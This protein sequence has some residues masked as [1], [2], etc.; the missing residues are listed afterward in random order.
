MRN[1]Y[2]R[3][4]LNIEDP[5]SAFYAYLQ[6]A[7]KNNSYI[8]YFT[9][10]T[11]KLI[12]DILDEILG[13]LSIDVLENIVNLPNVN[14][15]V[16]YLQI[17]NSSQCLFT[18]KREIRRF[19]ELNYIQKILLES[20]ASLLKE[21]INEHIQ[22]KEDT[23]NPLQR[24]LFKYYSSRILK[25]L[26]NHL[27]Q[28][29]RIKPDDVLRIKE[30]IKEP[31]IIAE[32][33]IE[34]NQEMLKAAEQGDVNKVNLLLNNG[35][36]VNY[37][38]DD[39]NTAVTIALTKGYTRVLKAFV[40]HKPD[41]FESAKINKVIILKDAIK[42]Y[43]FETVK[44][45]VEEGIL[46]DLTDDEKNE[47][48]IEA[49]LTGSIRVVELL[50]SKGINPNNRHSELK[51]IPLFRVL[52]RDVA[53][54]KL[55]IKYKADLN[56]QGEDGETLL[57]KATRAKRTK[58]VKLL[59]AYGAD[60]T[61]ESRDG[62]TALISAVLNY[63]FIAVKLLL[64]H[65]AN[66]HAL[67]IAGSTAFIEAIKHKQHIITKLIIDE[68]KEFQYNKW[69]GTLIL[70][71]A[72]EAKS[73]LI[74]NLVLKLGINP[75]VQASYYE[76]VIEKI[77]RNK[78]SP[79]NPK[80]ATEQKITW[81]VKLLL[82]Y[83]ADPNYRGDKRVTRE[84]PLVIAI[85]NS[86]K[87]CV[88]WL[89][90]Y[91]AVIRNEG[92]GG[93]ALKALKASKNKEILKAI[94]KWVKFERQVIDFGE[95]ISDIKT[96]LSSKI[97]KIK[98]TLRLSKYEPKG[99]L[100][101]TLNIGKEKSRLKTSNKPEL[102]LTDKLCLAIKNK[103]IEEFKQLLNLNISLITTEDISWLLYNTVVNDQLEMAKIILAHKID[104][105]CY[106]DYIDYH[107]LYYAVQKNKIEFVR[108]FLE[109]NPDLNMRDQNS[110]T[111]VFNCCFISMI[112]IMRLLLANNARVNVRNVWGETP[113]ISSVFFK[114]D[115]LVKLLL[116]YKP[117][118]NI[119]DVFGYT[120]LSKAAKKGNF[121]V[122]KMLI[123]H[124]AELSIKDW[125][126]STALSLA[127]KNRSKDI[128]R[129]ILENDYINTL[130]G[131]DLGEGLV[132]SAG[133]GFDHITRSLLKQKN[134]RD[135]P[136]HRIQEALMVSAIKG[137][138]E[139][140]RMLLEEEIVSTNIKDG[141]GNTPLFYAV[142]KGFTEIV[143]I[144]L[145]YGASSKSINKSGISIIQIAKQK[146][147]TYI[148]RIILENSLKSKLTGAYN[149]RIITRYSFHTKYLQFS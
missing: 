107:P 40:M 9:R 100:N 11:P 23:S 135:C 80:G 95:R 105:N 99:K 66:P 81:M 8:P 138:P 20:Y 109:H 110:N 124:K 113:L 57:I 31:T 130:S 37:R 12:N 121:N 29:K 119:R 34:L 59:L 149:S 147:H 145:S 44:L 78:I 46:N 33:K 1:I 36:D 85:N 98:E 6:D 82:E 69:Y 108:L 58:I 91:G 132:W 136:K 115:N 47:A 79:L 13:S 133:E 90:I 65:G 97:N 83:G 54:L 41:I 24:E 7:G 103:R 131:E 96:N 102:N 86:F 22:I 148:I 19:K 63:S 117:D 84:T 38:D 53:L 104:I 89:L 27:W 87:K 112:E 144:L 30:A 10:K 26:I 123:E 134:M 61:V 15:A 42:A 72:I 127:I 62:S 32:D 52:Y 76:T 17:L 114:Y 116:D 77:L 55:L 137:F 92:S 70:V 106:K 50:L 5:N 21:G 35:A 74:L 118:L 142:E 28:I 75:N 48:L 60:A 64:K 128:I 111:P 120:A 101:E 68:T 25:F 43:F 51:T 3:E 143:K 122:V 56:V 139:I 71:A 2:V 16:A 94:K 73:I 45:L 93:D 141:L 49:I 125:K 146:G 88:K 4:L 39:G 18:V 129:L 14:R 126:E 140:V 67:N